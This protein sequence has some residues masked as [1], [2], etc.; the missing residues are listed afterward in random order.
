MKP[1]MKMCWRM[2]GRQRKT[3]GNS[4]PFGQRL[5]HS[6]YESPVFFPTDLGLSS[7]TFSYCIDSNWLEP[8]KE[9]LFQKSVWSLPGSAKEWLFQKNAF[10]WHWAT[11]CH[12]VVRWMSYSASNQHSF[13]LF[14]LTL[15]NPL[16]LAATSIH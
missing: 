3:A 6:L 2:S 9:W 12:Q 14:F 8:Q 13:Q 16:H 1:G 10:E 11:A 15:F 5:A 7:S 4:F